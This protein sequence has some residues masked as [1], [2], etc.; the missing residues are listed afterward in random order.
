MV[1]IFDSSPKM[2]ERSKRVKKQ[3]KGTKT[4]HQGMYWV[5]HNTTVS[6]Q[7][8]AINLLS[9][10]FSADKNK[11]E[12]EIRQEREELIKKPLKYDQT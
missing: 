9:F 8:N 11:I 4:L 1:Q 12:R 5:L 7:W 3:L 6:D 10:L 2:L